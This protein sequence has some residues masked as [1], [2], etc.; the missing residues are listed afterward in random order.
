M[1][2][3]ISRMIAAIKIPFIIVLLYSFIVR[4]SVRES[5]MGVIP[6]GLINAKS[7]D[8]DINKNDEDSDSIVTFYLVM[9]YLKYL[10][11]FLKL[12]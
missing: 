4:F 6:I 8:I 9:L 11:H 2:A 7:E 12:F 5:T 1:R 3:K 10:I